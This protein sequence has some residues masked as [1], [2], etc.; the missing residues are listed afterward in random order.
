MAVQ[1]SGEKRKK[2]IFL[3]IDGTLVDFN[4]TM[5]ESTREALNRATDAGHM[6]VINTGRLAA[7]V[8]PWIFDKA[9]FDG[10]IS[11]SGANIR[12][13]GERVCL[14]CWSEGQIAKFRDVCNSVGAAIFFHTEKNLIAAPGAVEHQVEFFAQY[15]LKRC[16][17]E[18]LLE[19]VLVADPLGREDIEKGIYIDSKH[20]TSEMQELLGSDFRVDA[21]S[22]GPIPATCGEI[23]LAGVTKASGIERLCEYL[24][25]DIADTVAIGDGGNDIEMIRRAAVGIAMGNAVEPL[26][27][28]ADFVTDDLKNDGF[29][30]AIYRWVL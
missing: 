21:Y 27:E 15:G 17:F 30:K 18:S 4:A 5:P 14:E 10:F 8:Y 12:W 6:L 23:T 7:Q 20:T 16:Q 11:S 13:K 28:A 1:S 29:A 25:V 9:R 22:F 24:G 3:D 26:K 19:S 2:L